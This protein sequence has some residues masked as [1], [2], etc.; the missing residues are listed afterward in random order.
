MAV[1]IPPLKF[2]TPH[3]KGLIKI[4]SDLDEDEI[5][6]ANENITEVIEA[7]NKK[8]QEKKQKKWEAHIIQQ[9]QQAGGKK[10]KKKNID[11]ADV[12][13]SDSDSDSSS[14]DMGGQQEEEKKE[15]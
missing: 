9:Q 11:L 4:R 7:Y 13:F 10:L 1:T 12:E 6:E 14:S 8:E 2:F 3:Q 5:E 15:E